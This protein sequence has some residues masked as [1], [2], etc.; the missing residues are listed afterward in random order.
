MAD[1]LI[2]LGLASN[3]VHFIN[4]T[5]RLIDKE[6]EPHGFDAT[7]LIKLSELE[8]VTRSLVELNDGMKF[9]V[10]RFRE[11]DDVKSRHE[12]VKQRLKHTKPEEKPAETPDKRR[13]REHDDTLTEVEEQLSNWC[14]DCNE[15]AQA[16]LG[17]LSDLKSKAKDSAQTWSTFREALLSVWKEEHVDTHLAHLKTLRDQMGE[18]VLNAVQEHVRFLEITYQKLLD[19]S[20]VRMQKE[21]LRYNDRISDLARTQT[22]QLDDQRALDT[23]KQQR[24]EAAEKH[25]YQRVILENLVQLGGKHDPKSFSLLLS[26]TAIQQRGET[27]ERQILQHLKFHDMRSRYRDI[28]KAHKETFEWVFLGTDHGD[29]GDSETISPT[30]S[31]NDHALQHKPESPRRG[32]WMTQLTRRFSDKSERSPDWDSY[33]HWL[34]G[35]EPLYWIKGK[36]GSGKSTLMKL[37]HDHERLR[38]ELRSWCKGTHLVIAGFFFWN[39]GEVMQMSKE[40]LLRALLYQGIEDN[41]SLVP[42]LF[43]DRWQYNALFGLDTRPWTLPELEDAFRTLVSDDSRSY[44]IMIDGLDEYEGDPK[45]LAEFILECCVNRRHVKVCVSSRPWLEFETAFDGRPSLSLE[46]LTE[47]DIELYVKDRFLQSEMFLKLQE[48]EPE[49]C[50]DLIHEIARSSDG[51]FLWVQL[52]MAALLEGI[53]DNDTTKDLRNRLR[54]YPSELKELFE[55]TWARIKEDDFQQS[56]RLFRLIETADAPLSLLSLQYADDGPYQALEDDFQPL[57]SSELGLLADT[58][59]RRLGHL[60]ANLFEVPSYKENGAWANVQYIHRTAKD[61]VNKKEIQESIQN[62]SPESDYDIKLALCTGYLR[63]LKRSDPAN[64]SF[65][66][67]QY[68]ATSCLKLSKI[69]EAEDMEKNLAILTQLDRAATKLVGTQ[70]PDKE[71]W[72]KN[73]QSCVPLVSDPHWTNACPQRTGASTFFDFAFLSGFY[74]YV[75]NAL[76]EGEHGG[77]L[78]LPS[79]QHRQSNNLLATAIERESVDMRFVRLLLQHNAQ[80]NLSVASSN[81]KTPWYLLLSN[82]STG[83]N[84]KSNLTRDERIRLGELAALF[85]EYNANPFVTVQKTP[86][87]EI[88]RKVV[89]EVDGAFAERL[90]AQLEQSKKTN[91]HLKPKQSKLNRLKNFLKS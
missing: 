35:Y 11:K 47:S 36:P 16:L 58:T 29:G 21:E 19:D 88:L 89:G 24:D 40:G 1:P 37:L 72:R 5:T 43:P 60:C 65:D 52:V 14:N 2:A 70:N 54:E 22:G 75:E 84:V 90:V 34:Q 71:Q 86:A 49:R 9:T 20:L 85:L 12:R 33:R 80:P 59:R 67:F 68:L 8:T 79:H 56:S 48:R 63:C 23:I 55:K 45:A 31:S 76:R 69:V 39:S 78:E 32:W 73:I 7:S 41:L 13:E 57:T 3:V 27:L 83:I 66:C 64:S 46:Q 74:S 10:T 42:K 28:S 44:L 77:D 4:F 91:A 18:S 53:Q 51:V 62:G 81:Y 50:E 26:E 61:F 25:R 6:N 82:M 87:D 15:V 38:Q 30:T 17:A